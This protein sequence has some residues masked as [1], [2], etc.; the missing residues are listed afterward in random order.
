VSKLLAI[1]AAQQ[2]NVAPIVPFE[3]QY[4]KIVELHF[5]ANESLFADQDLSNPYTMEHCIA[6]YLRQQNARYGAGGY[7]VLRAIYGR[8]SLFDGEAEARR[9]HIGCDIFGEAGTPVFAPIAG[10]IHSFADNPALGDYGA[11]IILKH[12]L[13][14]EVF[15][16]LYGHLA[17]TD[18][19]RL[20][21]D[22]SV[23]QGQL[24][25]HFG[26]I[27]ENGNWSPHL[28]F[29]I[30]ADI[31]DYCG[32]YPGVCRYSEREWYLQNCPNPVYLLP[33]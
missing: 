25:A 9:F 33:W 3:R 13:S 4:D 12:T 6:Q 21:V 5:A 32:D 23:E 16:T 28:H 11:T 2:N 22:M 7:G 30:I 15:Y 8:S 14:G 24:F 18:L 10:K 31:G 19:D 26:T 17:R 20:V 27:E 29:Q 1:L